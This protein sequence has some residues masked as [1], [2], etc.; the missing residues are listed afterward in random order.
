MPITLIF[1][2]AMIQYLYQ[3]HNFSKLTPKS[4]NVANNE[5]Q[6]IFK[7]RS[8]LKYVWHIFLSSYHRITMAQVVNFSILFLN[9]IF[10]KWFERT[11]KYFGAL[12]ISVE[13]CKKCLGNTN[14]SF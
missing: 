7:E 5:K 9:R 4:T 3:T 10:S 12:Y 13:Y 1:Y 2:T 6:I 8:N 11:N 14:V